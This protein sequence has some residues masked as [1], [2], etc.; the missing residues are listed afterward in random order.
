MNRLIFT[1]ALFAIITTYGCS[2]AKLSVANEQMERGEYYDAQRTYRKVYNKLTK[3]EERPQRGEIA[4]KMGLCYRKLSM[5]ARASAAFQNAI[6]YEWPDSTA[7][8]FL[9]QALQAEGRYR[10]AQNA[11]TEYLATHPSD[12][13]TALTGIAGCKMGAEIKQNPTRYIVK[14]AKL[15][16]SRRADFAPMF[17]PGSDYDILYFTSTNEKVTGSRR[18]EITG[19]KKHDIWMARK[20]ERGQWERPQ[21]AEGELNT[22]HEEGIISFS[23]D[24]STMY[25]T[26]ARRELNAHTAVEIFTS[27][28]SDASWSAPVKF[29]ITADTL[30]SYGHPAVSPDGNWLYFCSDMPGGYG[31]KDIWRINLKERAGSLENLGEFINT[32]GDEEFPY[33]RTDSI[34]Y[35]SSNGHAGL[36]GLDIFK[37]QMTP[38][39]GWKVV[40]MGTP[41]NSSSDDF[42]ITFGKGERIFQLKPGRR[43]RIRPHIF[44]H[45][46]RFEN[47]HKWNCC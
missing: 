25:L 24:G 27:Q 26:R 11:Y 14:N 21:P 1:I 39:G 46:A 23:P 10:E 37:A 9:A 45:P 22:E 17:L 3:R 4:Y 47:K 41:I 12:S 18:S 15:F 5:N 19:M 29:E 35:F 38:M 32:P 33:I 2:G 7:I 43:A 42:G 40:N 44:I 31:G 28:R 16:N 8:L 20:N 36:G 6:R 34:M 13:T 30:S